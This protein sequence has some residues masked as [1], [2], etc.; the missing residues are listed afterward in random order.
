MEASGPGVR[1]VEN[2]T[3]GTTSRTTKEG[4]KVSYQLTVLQQPSRARA[5]G[6]GAKCKFFNSD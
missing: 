5:C 4:R 3:T 1:A 6:A 2:E